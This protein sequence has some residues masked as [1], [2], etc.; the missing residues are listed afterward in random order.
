MKLK[1]KVKAEKENLLPEIIQK[2]DWIDLRTSSDIKIRGFVQS[3]IDK[4]VNVRIADMITYIP[5]G[6]CMKLPKG[7]EAIVVSRSS[8]PKRLGIVCPNSFGVIDYTYNSNKDEWKYPAIGL[9][10]SYIKKGERICQFRI[11]L[12]QKATFWN[13]LKWFLSSGIKIVKVDDLGDNERGG[14][15]STN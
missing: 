8:T 2:G 13:K 15:G 5:L 1:I 14:L 10:D 3:I 12:S 7:F 11:Q 9:K 4:N 6:V